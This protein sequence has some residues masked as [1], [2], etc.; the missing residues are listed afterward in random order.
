MS[1][2][3]ITGATVGRLDA[4]ELPTEASGQIADAFGHLR[5]EVH[6]INHTALELVGDGVEKGKGL[7]HICFC[8]AKAES[9]QQSA[10]TR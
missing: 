6:I 8:S 10:T 9:L 1:T 5:A 4:D 2:A 7:A 3:V